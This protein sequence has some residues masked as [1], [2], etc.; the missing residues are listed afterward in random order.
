M[1]GPSLIFDKS[2]F[3]S[4]SLDES[5][6]LDN[7]Y[8]NNITPLFFVETLADLEKNIRKG[9]TPEQIVGDLARKTPE[10]GCSG[11]YHRNLM[12]SELSGKENVEMTGRPCIYYGEYVKLGD[13][14]GLIFREPPEREAF[15]RWQKHEFLEIERTIAKKWREGLVEDITEES[16]KKFKQL[17][18][19]KNP[20]SL[21]ELKE[22]VDLIIDDNS[23][24]NLIFCLYILG[25]SPEYQIP[26]IN[27]WNDLG[28]VSIKEFAPYSS[29]V[30][31]VDL[32]YYL[33]V[34]AN[35]F[36]G[37][38][39]PQT[40]KIDLAYLYYLPFCN[41]F[42]SNDNFH[43]GIVNYFMRT[44]QTFINGE[45]FKEDMAALNNYYSK[46]P[47][48][49][50]KRG[51]VTFASMPPTDDDFLTTQMWNKYMSP[52]WKDMK[53]RVK[54]FDGTDVVDSDIE[55]E[56]LDKINNFAK[57]AK[58]VEDGVKMNSDEVG[59][60]I[61]KHMVHPRKGSWRIFPP[62]IENSNKRILD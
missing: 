42:T 17:F 47:E 3:Q 7:F 36:N 4:L 9:K 23:K 14:T 57:K 29:Y 58:P 21:S 53:D 39:H 43:K 26:I 51:V 56:L 62:E 35:L 1:M 60:M 37:F 22:L 45:D 18:V 54:K 8:I 19:I 41:I 12:F 48:D 32:F 50:K 27:R 49:I 28:R 52:Q 25:V 16:L 46:L 59:N 24:E 61:M 34:A 40:H 11:A 44:D 20:Q 2:T 33:G 6:W 15:N 10:T 31:S 30:L 38:H 55:K 5:V 13:Q